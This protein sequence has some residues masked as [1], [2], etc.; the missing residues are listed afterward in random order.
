M[1]FLAQKHRVPEKAVLAD[2]KQMVSQS[3][4]VEQI[5]AR[6]LHKSPV[7]VGGGILTVIGQ[8]RLTPS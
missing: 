5:G 7:K 3:D 1:I 8:E 2:G 4:L 6:D